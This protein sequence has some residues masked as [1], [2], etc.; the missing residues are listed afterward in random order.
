MHDV[1]VLN[2]VLLALL[3]QLAGLATTLLATE[4]HIVLVAGGF[5]LD[6]AALEVGVDDA[7][8][9]RGLCTDGDSP[10]LSLLSARQRP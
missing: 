5:G 2:D 9:L 3:A 4:C 7:R 8:S 1:A 6:E 10:G